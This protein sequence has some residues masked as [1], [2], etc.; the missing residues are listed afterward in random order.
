MNK[1]ED[2]TL[3][4]TEE[5]RRKLEKRLLGDQS[6]DTS[7]DDPADPDQSEKTGE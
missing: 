3:I 4:Q 1:D 2:K 6:D 5:D 7:T